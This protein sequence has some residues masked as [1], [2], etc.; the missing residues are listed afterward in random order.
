MNS[1]K[2][3]SISWKISIADLLQDSKDAT[4]LQFKK[5]SF[6]LLYIKDKNPAEYNYW[7]CAIKIQNFNRKS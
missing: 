4:G 2:K 3:S 5:F 7:A 6:N 1:E